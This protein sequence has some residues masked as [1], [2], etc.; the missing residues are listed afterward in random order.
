ML[1]RGEKGRRKRVLAVIVAYKNSSIRYTLIHAAPLPEIARVKGVRGV[2]RTNTGEADAPP[3]PPHWITKGT[4]DE[5]RNLFHV[6]YHLVSP[7]TGVKDLIY[8]RYGTSI[9]HTIG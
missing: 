9:P 8:C 3:P 6:E 7:S 5:H 2:I 4:V 1:R